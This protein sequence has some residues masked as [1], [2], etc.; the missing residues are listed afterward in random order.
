MYI[1]P[2]VV[3]CPEWPA[4]EVFDDVGLAALE[5]ADVVGE[6]FAV[7]D[8]LGIVVPPVVAPT[9]EPVVVGIEPAEVFAGAPDA[10]L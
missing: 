6:P 10:P 7:V 4:P 1:P 5:T 8:G 9:M 2:N 3:V